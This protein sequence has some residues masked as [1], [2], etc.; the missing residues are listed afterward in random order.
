MPGM[1]MRIFHPRSIAMPI[2]AMSDPPMEKISVCWAANRRLTALA[3]SAI[4]RITVATPAA[5][6]QVMATIPRLVR[7][8][9]AKY[10]GSITDTQHG[11]RSATTPPRNEA[12]SVVDINRSSIVPHIH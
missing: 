4:G 2:A 8:V 11:A 5:N 9:E 7:K 6:T 1:G 12:S 3:P 10:A